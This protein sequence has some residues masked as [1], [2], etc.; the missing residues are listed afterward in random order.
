[1]TTTTER[2]AAP[3]QEQDFY[4]RYVTG[5][6]AQPAMS[7]VEHAILRTLAVRVGLNPVGERVRCSLP[8]LAERIGRDS[9]NTASSEDDGPQGSRQVREG[10]ESLRRR[11]WLDGRREGRGCGY[12]YK[13]LVNDHWQQRR[14]PTWK[15]AI[16]ASKC[17]SLQVSPVGPT[18]EKDYHE[19]LWALDEEGVRTGERK[20]WAGWIGV[21]VQRVLPRLRRLAEAEI[22]VTME[23]LPPE[24]RR[25]D[26]RGRKGKRYRLTV[27][28]PQKGTAPSGAKRHRA[29]QFQ[30]AETVRQLTA[31]LE[32][33][34]ANEPQAPYADGAVYY[35]ATDEDLPDFDEL[36]TDDATTGP[37]DDATTG[38]GE[39]ATTAPGENEEL[40][41]SQAPPEL[42]EPQAPSQPASA[43]LDPAQEQPLPAKSTQRPTT[44]ELREQA[45]ELRERLWHPELV[46]KLIEVAEGRLK[47][48]NHMTLRRR[49]RAFYAPVIALQ[50]EIGN[51]EALREVL[52]TV[53]RDC[54]T[55]RDGGDW[56]GFARKVAS[57]RIASSASAPAP[58]SNAAVKVAHSPERLSATLSERLREAYAL[59][60]TGESADA[61]RV[62][63]RLLRGAVPVVAPVLYDG[64]EGLARAAIIEA[65]KS[66]SSETVARA[67]LHAPVDYLPGSEYPHAAPLACE[68]APVALAP[69]AN[70]EAGGDTAEAN[71]N[72]ASAELQRAAQ[73]QLSLLSG[74]TPTA[75]TV[76]PAPKLETVRTPEANDMNT[77]AD[78]G[79]IEGAIAR[80]RPMHEHKA[81]ASALDLLLA[82]RPD[83]AGSPRPD[84]AAHEAMRA[85]G[86]ELET[87]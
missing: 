33:A 15:C 56:L 35:D 17:L 70:T 2:A 16:G 49:V 53:R 46:D 21:S 54:R 23:E 24:P 50:E 47:A 13:T 72:A 25:S 26:E 86:V 55:L 78:T 58:G 28:L 69:T 19:L 6:M 27:I 7:P 83:D 8:A 34:P 63:A 71:R 4:A 57:H 79:S 41:V 42:P 29:R 36:P 66:G 59:N 62:L 11:E 32:L 75:A 77:G 82:P 31:P 9:G 76:A 64:D 37:G 60:K 5:L 43:D 14:E 12:A 85:H 3:L 61:Q 44:A 45:E 40:P 10:Y 73:Q 39:D 48:G 52:E 74:K 87:A 22:G 51:R 84:D 30:S 81:S 80:I 38:P 18:G 67:N 1:M 20:D 68:T 65:Y